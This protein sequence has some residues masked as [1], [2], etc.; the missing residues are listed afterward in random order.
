[1]F[2]QVE[3]L[4]KEVAAHED[5]VEGMRKEV[6]RQARDASQIEKKVGQLV[7]LAQNITISIHQMKKD[8]SHYSKSLLSQNSISWISDFINKILSM[9]LFILTDTYSNMSRNQ[10]PSLHIDFYIIFFIYFILFR[11]VIVW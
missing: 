5:K 6:R 3:A 8:T 11:T 10:I 9:L 2:V 1:M 7:F 4:V